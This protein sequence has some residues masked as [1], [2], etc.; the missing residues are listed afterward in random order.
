MDVA[1]DHPLTIALLGSAFVDIAGPR[2]ARPPVW[3]PPRIPV[4]HGTDAFRWT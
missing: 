4:V 2:I 1:P 3:N